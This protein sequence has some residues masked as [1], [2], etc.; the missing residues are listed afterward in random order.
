MP[1]QNKRFYKAKAVSWALGEA[2]TGT[3]Q[4]AVEFEILNPDAP[5]EDRRLTWYGYLSDATFDRTIESLRHC[6]WTGDDLSEIAEGRGGLDANEVSLT[7]EDEEYQGQLHAK[8][9]W[10]NR[11]GGLAVKSPIVGDRAKAFA[12]Q[13]RDRIRA[14]DAGQGRR[15]A[16][17]GGARTPPPPGAPPP[18]AP[19][20]PRPTDVSDD[21][22]F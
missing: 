18:G 17:N 2:G 12:A 8:V 9:Q 11:G 1:G 14:L 21:I 13:V 3:P 19:P 10:V 16:P 15:A 6:G 5:A 22:P 7:V 4:V 20:P